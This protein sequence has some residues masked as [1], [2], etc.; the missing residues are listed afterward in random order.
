[1]K[2]V[3]RGKYWQ[4]EFKDA[5]GRRRRASTGCLENEKSLAQ[6]RAVR[7][8]QEALEE[9]K[10]IEATNK[11]LGEALLEAYPDTIRVNNADKINH[12]RKRR[13]WLIQ[14]HGDELLLRIDYRR[15]C[16]FTKQWE[17]IGN[18]PA[19]I[20][21]KMAFISKAM[22]HACVNLNW[23]SKADLPAKF[24]RKEE[25][26][27]RIVY[28]EPREVK[29]ICRVLDAFELEGEPAPMSWSN[30]KRY[31]MFVLDVGSRLNETRLIEWTDIKPNG[32]GGFQ[33][34]LRKTNTKTGKA[35]VVPLTKNAYGILQE[36]KEEGYK[37]PFIW[38]NSADSLCA[39]FRKVRTAVG[40]TEEYT[41][42][43]LRHTCA[44]RLVQSGMQ[45]M[46]VKEWLGHSTVKTTERYVHLAPTS[47]DAGAEILE[48]MG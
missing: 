34:S 21:R 13:D 41:L 19:T 18:S 46:L 36:L 47:L 48:S 1:M 27:E 10:G 42:H 31:F 7:I 6:A 22:K 30:L 45:L 26:N 8:V 37:K 39:M 28:Y 25:R 44:S 40:L 17:E 32:R 14:H 2:L 24:P 4:V 9:T 12:D 38:I 3:M 35:R 23:I 15:L 20:N 11:T 43:T 5:T 16:E 29:E 33:L